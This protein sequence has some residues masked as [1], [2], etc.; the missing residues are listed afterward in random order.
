MKD[1]FSHIV[2][3]T[4]ALLAFV[5]LTLSPVAIFCG[6]G[7]GAEI[8]PAK[9]A[10]TDSDYARFTPATF[11]THEPARRKIGS[12]NPDFG[13]LSAA[14]FFASNEQR[15]KNG[16]PALAF[17]PALARAAQGHSQAMG[18]KGFFSHTNP[19]DGTL[20]T[21]WQRMAAVG[22]AGG[23]R[24]ENIASGGGANLTYLEAADMF[25][26]MWM[27]SAGH[28][29]NLLD[30]NVRFLGCGAAFSRSKQLLSTQNFASDP[31]K[32]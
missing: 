24:T 26:T 13:L 32:P 5:T 22:I 11:R 29:S 16:R 31:A 25:L 28:R 27:K 20:R 9:S 19:N 10:W 14:I 8:A 3:R 4:V 15:L 12:E 6:V 21:P 30:K 23:Y 18:G 1:A 2:R 7:I 17:S